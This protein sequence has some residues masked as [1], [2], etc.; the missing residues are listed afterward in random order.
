[1]STKTKKTNKV[2]GVFDSG[3]GGISLLAEAMRRMPEEDYLFYADVAHA[4]YGSRSERWVR[5]RVCELADEMMKQGLKAL[6]VACNTATAVAVE[7]LREHLDIPVIGTEP[8]LRPARRSGRQPIISLATPLTIRSERYAHLK[9]EC[10]SDVKV[11]DVPCPGLAELIDDGGTDQ[12]IFQYLSAYLGEYT[13]I[14]AAVVL[15][16]THY[17][18]LRP[19]IQSLLPN[20]EIFDGNAGAAAQLERMI[21]EEERGGSGKLMVYSSSPGV[22]WDAR[23][24]R[25]LEKAKA[26][27]AS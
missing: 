19:M 23:F 7:A 9:E 4:P 3:V 6:L 16:C 14:P 21:P 24:Q 8:A 27:Y 17:V 18:F 22:E 15:G 10:C 1:M 5:K 20:A 26:I 25:Y 12:E 13:T 2:I 11:I